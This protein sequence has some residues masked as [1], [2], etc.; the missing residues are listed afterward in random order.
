MGEFC[1]C[2]S[3]LRADA[4]TS[5]QG[6]SE[7]CRFDKFDGGCASV[8]SFSGRS[9]IH[10]AS[11]PA[12]ATCSAPWALLIDVS[13]KPMALSCL[14]AVSKE[15]LGST[16]SSSSWGGAHDDTRL[17]ALWRARSKA[18]AAVASTNLNPS[19]AS[20][21]ADP[22]ASSAKDDG[23]PWTSCNASVASLSRSNATASS[24]PSGSGAATLS[25]P[26]SRSS[27]R[28][29]STHRPPASGRQ[30]SPSRS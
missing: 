27:T 25:C 23:L 5:S 15:V 4:S 28:Q 3:I 21:V 6:I 29:R 19:T 24:S 30:E 12:S 1:D 7:T 11:N 26:E 13:S 16:P 10:S 14:R 22:R 20:S 18:W 17:R 9:S 2:A 8:T